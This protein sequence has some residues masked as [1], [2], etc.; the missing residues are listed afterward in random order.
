M[1]KILL[2]G[3]NIMLSA[4][5]SDESIIREVAKWFCVYFSTVS[6]AVKL[7]EVNA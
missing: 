5:A 1:N 3:E 6:R 4:Y 7:F 2:V